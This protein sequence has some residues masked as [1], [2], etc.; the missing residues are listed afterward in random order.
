MRQYRISTMPHT[1][2][3]GSVYKRGRTWW[4]KFYADGKSVRESSRSHRRGDALALLKRRLLEIKSGCQPNLGTITVSEML[5]GLIADYE[6]NDRK[7][8][9]R[10]ELSARQINCH[11]G[12][13]KAKN[14][15]P[16]QLAS[17]V[18]KRKSLG[19]SNATINR[20]LAALRRAFKLAHQAHAVS[21]VPVM[22]SLKEAAPRSGFFEYADFLKLRDHLPDYLKGFTTFAYLTGM[23]RSEIVSLRWDQV[24]LFEG[25]IHLK[26]GT[27]KNDQARDLPIFPELR[28][29]L[30]AQQMAN[31]CASPF[32]F[33]RQG[34][35]IGWHYK[36]WRTACQAA[37]LG[38]RLLH[39]FRRTAARNLRRAGISQEIAMRITGHRTAE[40]FRRYNIT[41][42][43]DLRQ[44]ARRLSLHVQAQKAAHTE[45]K[46]IDGH[47]SPASP[48]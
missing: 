22:P 44:A 7:S 36:S 15:G 39:D 41:D 31:V 34:R 2:F 30:D 10:A 20:E 47:A 45:R 4:I 35:Q 6:S 38:R 19:K 5:K 46:S 26:A 32:V 18:R 29:V 40:V 9:R 21:H 23:R 37:G 17:F 16:E 14:V 24:D 3:F 13:L 11:L 8:T 25:W 12:D 1:A 33:T 27:T 48:S 43:D 28:A 42:A